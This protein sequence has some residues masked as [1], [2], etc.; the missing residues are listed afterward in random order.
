MAAT[1]DPTPS[2]IVAACLEI[3]A[4]WTPEERMRRLRP[5]MRPT[6]SLCD[7][8]AME[9]TA[10]AYGRHHSEREAMA[11]VNGSRLGPSIECEPKEP[12]PAHTQFNASR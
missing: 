3:Q 7:G 9:M 8:R 12:I 4:G 2:E 6:I 11:G 1:P 10:E 5:D